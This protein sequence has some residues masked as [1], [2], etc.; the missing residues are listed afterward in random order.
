MARRRAS[1]REGPLAELFKA[2]E[3]AQRQ[4]EKEG[5]PGKE[6][7]EERPRHEDMATVESAAAVPDPPSEPPP[8]GERH[9]EPVSEPE[10]TPER[11]AAV[12]SLRTLLG[13]A[14]NSSTAAPGRR[15]SSSPS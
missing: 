1:M 7:G 8:S 2:T 10:P 6:P 12:R 11:P 9:A 4:S 15:T 14:S 13:A 3:A 5:E